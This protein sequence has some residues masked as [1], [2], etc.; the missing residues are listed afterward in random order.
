M[1]FTKTISLL[2]IRLG[3][4]ILGG[5]TLNSYMDNLIVFITTVADNI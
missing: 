3:K 1:I 5:P 2:I 4:H